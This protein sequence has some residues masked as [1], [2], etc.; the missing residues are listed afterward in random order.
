MFASGFGSA[1][2]AVLVAEIQECTRAEARTAARRLA[3]IGELAA[4]AT[5]HDEERQHWVADLWDCAAAEVATAMG[6]SRYRAGQQMAI[7]LALRDR[8][9][10]VA[11]LFAEG[12]I[13][14]EV[15]STITWRTH[16]VL[17]DEPLARVDAEIAQRA[18]NWGALGQ[19]RLELGID[20]V[21]ETHDPD[22]RRRF[23]EAAR[24]CDVQV[25]KPDDA[26]GTASVYGRLSASD[27]AL[28]KRCLEQ[29]TAEVCPDDP[30]NPGQLR[31][32]ALGALSAG[33]DRLACQCGSPQCPRGGAADPRAAAFVIYALT[34][35]TAP[36]PK[37]AWLRPNAKTN[38]DADLQADADAPGPAPEAAPPEAES[39]SE[40]EAEASAAPTPAAKANLWVPA[41]EAPLAG[42]AA[43]IVGGGVIPP[44]LL[45]ELITNGATV[46]S[47][48]RP[49]GVNPEPRYRPS[50]A[51]E[52]FVRLR[53]MTCRF[54]GCDRPAQYCDIDHTV[55]YPVG[56][57]H[58]SNLACLCRFHHLLKTFCGW[59]DQ[60]HP[61]GT[62]IWTAPS[63]HTYKTHP[64]SKLYFPDWNTTTAD[65]PPP[66]NPP[67]PRSAQRA[68]KM[69]RRRRTRA[70]DNE[71]RIHAE[72]QLNATTPRHYP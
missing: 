13:S 66:A 53:D 36:A 6:V 1:D 39:E 44:A 43:V 9:P 18:T 19:Q 15:I 46:R 11:A 52:R 27:A 40:T 68:L 57:T 61:D 17:G 30:R 58:A 37:P 38:T 34:D 51:C 20:A 8:L 16:L 67:P 63:G 50:R 70:A 56:L 72:R 5:E 71:T 23:H 54:P 32:A 48:Y 14:A 45:A 47:V 33:A 42:S 24:Q 26:T 49:A 3:A 21:V 60:Q 59:Q 65:L 10:K 55:P 12:Q 2:D 28:L 25:G 4:R 29:M 41:P 31:A 62:I 35:T 7:G 22:A 69:P 64:T